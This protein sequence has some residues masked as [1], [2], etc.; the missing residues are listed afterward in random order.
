LTL[1]DSFSMTGTYARRVPGKAADI[2]NLAVIIDPL[3]LRQPALAKVLTLAI[4]LDAAVG[5]LSFDSMQLRELRL[6]KAAP[7]PNQMPPSASL[8]VWLDRFSIPLRARGIDVITQVLN[9]DPPYASLLRWLQQSNVGL[10]LKD[11]H[12][13]SSPNHVFLTDTDRHLAIF[14]PMPL[15]L[16]K[17]RQW[18]DSPV[19]VAAVDPL[20]SSDP[21][22]LLDHEIMAYATLLTRRLN[23]TLYAF[24]ALDPNAGAAT[25]MAGA[26]LSNESHALEADRKRWALTAF[27]RRYALANQHLQVAIGQPEEHLPRFA[28]AHNADI[29]VMGALAR[30]RVARAEIGS[31]AKIALESLPCDVLLIK[32]PLA[33]R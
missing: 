29:V 15:L 14:C 10:V 12:H 7:V 17:P 13:Q 21:K 33:S 25:A 26:P 8:Q 30:D 2:T 5:L 31:T 24:H 22:A 32:S 27:I 28:I 19:V 6:A 16:S 3:S 9:G 4:R 18:R 1:E 11:I 23:G 20:H